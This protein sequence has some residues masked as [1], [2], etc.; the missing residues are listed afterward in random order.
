MNTQLLI[1]PNYNN[2]V[3]N[4]SFNI[5][6]E[7]VQTQYPL[8]DNG[9]FFIINEISTA[10]YKLDFKNTI[11]GA[12]ESLSL[13]VS[14]QN[15]LI[16]PGV[17]YTVR[18]NVD[19]ISVNGGLKVSINGIE[20]SLITTDGLHTFELAAGFIDQPY[21][22]VKI[23]GIN[24]SS[25]V[26]H[27]FTV[28]YLEIKEI[29][30]YDFDLTNVDSIALTLNIADIKE[31]EKRKSSFSKTITLPGSEK[32]NRIF[33]HYFEINAD[34]RF[35]PFK[36]L[37]VY[38]LQDDQVIFD[39]KLQ[40]VN[41]INN[42]DN[43]LYEVVLSGDLANIYSEQNYFKLDPFNPLSQTREL[44]LNELNFDEYNH[45][46]NRTNIVFSHEGII[47]KLGVDYENFEYG[48][49]QEIS[50]T[51]QTEDGLSFVFTNPH[52][53][54]VGDLLEITMDDLNL[55]PE[56]N[57]WFKVLEVISTT[58]VLVNNEFLQSSTGESGRAKKVTPKG[59]G[60]V[61]PRIHYTDIYT[62]K[63]IV[64][65]WKPAIYLKQ[66]VDKMF[67]RAQFNY[68]SEFFDSTFF[69]S[70]V[71]PASSKNVN[72]SAKYI[73]DN[74]VRVSDNFN[75]ETF[76]DFGNLY[77]DTTMIY[78]TDF[79]NGDYNST[80]DAFNNVSGRYITQKQGWY[81][82][83]M[84]LNADIS[85]YSEESDLDLDVVINSTFY[86]KINTLVV[87]KR[88]GVFTT[89]GTQ[90]TDFTFV[91]GS[92]SPNADGTFSLTQSADP[93]TIETF[94]FTGDEVIIVQRIEMYSPATVDAPITTIEETLD[95][96]GSGPD[97]LIIQ[98][99]SGIPT[100][101][102]TVA[103]ITN[104]NSV[105]TIVP[106]TLIKEGDVI[107]L[108]D[109]LSDQILVSNFFTS[110]V[111]M[112]NLYVQPSKESDRTLI[113]EPREDFYNT[114]EV[115]D[116]T[117]IVDSGQ[118]IEIT[119]LAEQVDKI[120]NYK[121]KDDQDF[122][123]KNYQDSI[124]RT[125]GEKEIIVNT[126]FSTN[127]NKTEIL[128]SPT[129][130]TD[131]TG[132]GAS[133]YSNEKPLSKIIK[134]LNSDESITN[135]IRILI[136]NQL[137]DKDG[138]VVVSQ[139][140][141][142]LQ[143]KKYMFA[144][145]LDNPYFPTVDLNF[146]QP[147]QTY[148]N[149]KKQTNNNLFNVYHRNSLQEV[150]DK[151]AKLY[152]A[153]LHLTGNDIAN[154]DFRKQYFINGTYFRLNKIEDYQVLEEGLTKVEFIKVQNKPKFV[155][156]IA[157]VNGGTFQ[158][159]GDT[160]Y[161]PI[162]NGKRT[163]DNRF[164]KT[165]NTKS[166]TIDTSFNNSISPNAQFIT[167]HNSSNNIIAPGYSNITMINTNG[168]TVEESNVTYINGQRIAADSP[169]S[170]G[171]F[172]P[173]IV[174]VSNSLGNLVSSSI[175][176]TELGYLDNVSSNIQTQLNN[177]QSLNV[178]LTSISGLTYASTSFV[179][180]TAAGTFALDTNTYATTSNL[181][182]TASGDA[183]GTVSGT[184]LPLTL[185]TVNSNI[186]TFNNVTVNAKGL[187]TSASNVSYITA[188]ITS[189]TNGQYLTYNGSAWV[190]TTT[191]F[192]SGSGTAAYIPY[193]ASATTLT[194]NGGFFW[195]TSSGTVGNR[196]LYI[197]G[198][199]SNLVFASSTT[200]STATQRITAGTGYIEF[201][202]AGGTAANRSITVV[203]SGGS[204]SGYFNVRLEGITTGINSSTVNGILL[205]GENVYIGK[206]VTYL[207]QSYM[208]TQITNRGSIAI[209]GSSNDVY[210]RFGN[211]AG[212]SSKYYHIPVIATASNGNAA[213]TSISFGGSVTANRSIKLN[214]NGLDVEI[215]CV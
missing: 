105:Q 11:A 178:N 175:T 169:I 76:Y 29:K 23:I 73:Q 18:I 37:D 1:K 135:N 12:S 26:E 145:H 8:D 95:E 71:I 210:P 136:I 41:I 5:E 202:N 167:L 206:E 98:F 107:R 24:N 186:G 28:D 7:S 22:I 126:D 203:A 189:P 46:Y 170:T 120:Y 49:D 161:A 151:D 158:L 112:F 205:Q 102:A 64:E 155:P 184:N 94:L 21:S 74:S 90:T 157:S 196:G 66:I 129:P 201:A 181:L 140:S 159:V 2:L 128:F 61:Y 50:D 118:D 86:A 38:L 127:E 104:R 142:D 133:V 31:P 139:T 110:I 14:Q 137:Y 54:V 124:K 183:T 81:N 56:Y 113:I 154:L 62:D 55:N 44:K 211:F 200:A 207:G 164:N 190:N 32:N 87:R 6:D 72:K 195:D 153:Y 83:N 9:S 149:L 166:V 156:T 182:A 3:Q 173:N 27:T 111:K 88:D 144:G 36:K 122:Q 131:R 168:V 96:G 42:Q 70:L 213:A 132:N 108:S 147:A 67:E 179:K 209:V 15:Y 177:K 47:Q 100:L 192:L 185:A 180:M 123:N 82:I 10:V 152:T 84:F 208:L 199:N 58:K 162:Y 114:E 101:R 214:I 34:S 191:S 99:V 16:I 150:V 19:T 63:Y 160:D 121:Y 117:E 215:P 165:F 93:A 65:D 174:P 134:N 51:E 193:Y 20:S 109:F 52:D 92:I 176:T 125:Y 116:Q 119:P 130:L 194:S 60:Y 59:E 40:L 204:S 43:I 53:Y 35:N 171:G 163:E 115:I 188:T 103:K 69:K 106:T 4:A 17:K 89:L 75:S 30:E 57:G 198:A 146:G 13:E 45:I 80:D 148:Y 48:A 138:Y 25:L 187:I 212:G 91:Q 79:T 33:G 97:G 143:Y 78:D 172:A 68:E 141:S 77:Q 197:T 39:G 85:I